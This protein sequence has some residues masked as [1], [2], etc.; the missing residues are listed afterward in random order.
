MSTKYFITLYQL[1]DSYSDKN[2]QQQ[3]QI[4]SVKPV[5]KSPTIKSINLNILHAFKRTQ[6]IRMQTDSNLIH[7]TKRNTKNTMY[8]LRTLI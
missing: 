3:I 1:N 2:I 7:H 5:I 8:T 6:S 4:I